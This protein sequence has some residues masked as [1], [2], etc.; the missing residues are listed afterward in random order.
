MVNKR[1]RE[2]IGLVDNVVDGGVGP[3]R[4][5]AADGGARG[6]RDL[7]WAAGGG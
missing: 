4:F 1:D 3:A 6:G 2:L 5:C 7:W